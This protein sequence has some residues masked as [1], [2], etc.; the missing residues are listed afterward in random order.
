[1]SQKPS[2][3]EIDPLLSILGDQYKQLIEVA[4]ETFRS[5]GKEQAACFSKISNDWLDILSA[6][7]DTYPTDEFINVSV[8]QWGHTGRGKRGKLLRK[9][10]QNRLGACA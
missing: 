3:T 1:M 6:I 8:K 2:P 7:H 9:K 10:G 4:E 5:L